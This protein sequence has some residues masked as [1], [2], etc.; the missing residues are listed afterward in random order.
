MMDPYRHLT[1]LG[2]IA[3]AAI[4]YGMERSRQTSFAERHG[5]VPSVVVPAVRALTGGEV[6]FSHVQSLARTVSA[7]FLHGDAEHLVYNMVFLWTFG[8]LTSQLLGQWWALVVFLV[9]GICGNIAQIVLEPESAVPI[10]GASGAICGLEGVYLGLAMR[11]QLP[12][13]TVWPLAYAVPPLH[14]GAFA[15]AGFLGDMYFLAN[16][17]QGI[18]YGAHAGGLLSGLAI[19]AVITSIY[20]TSSAYE[21][22]G[23]KR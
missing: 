19:A 18:A 23:R 11:W 8:Y 10:I 12:W 14:L 21:R 9:C 6:T 13:A 17:G 20:P 22:G 4:V 7:Q 15:L 1:I 3:V 5:A 16:H 2:L